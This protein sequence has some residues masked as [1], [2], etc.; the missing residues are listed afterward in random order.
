M[1][2]ILRHSLTLVGVGEAGGDGGADTLR[3]LVCGWWTGETTWCVDVMKLFYLSQ[4]KQAQ[5]RFVP[6]VSSIES[7]V[8][9]NMKSQPLSM[10]PQSAPLV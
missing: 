9:D 3:K 2:S 6:Q 5:R 7:N 8:F 1:R 10:S 4:Y